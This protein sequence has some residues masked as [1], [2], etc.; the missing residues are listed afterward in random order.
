MPIPLDEY[1][2]FKKPPLKIF[3][4]THFV[5]IHIIKMP[6]SLLLPQILKPQWKT[7]FTAVFLKVKS[8]W[9]AKVTSVQTLKCSDPTGGWDVINIFVKREWWMMQSFSV[10]K[11]KVY[12]TVCYER[13][14]I[15]STE[16]VEDPLPASSRCELLIEVPAV[17]QAFKETLEMAKQ[18]PVF[19]TDKTKLTKKG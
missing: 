18:D 6:L 12:S 5:M 14:D 11:W 15:S 13:D 7:R 1:V 17:R 9:Q 8:S 3:L 10:M 16:L 19:G 2:S 4:L